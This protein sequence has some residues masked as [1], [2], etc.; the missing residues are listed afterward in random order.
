MALSQRSSPLGLRHFVR[1]RDELA[2]RERMKIDA[3]QI[4]ARTLDR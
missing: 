3:R 2:A 1:V 4:A